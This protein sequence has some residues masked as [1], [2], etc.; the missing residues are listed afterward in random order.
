MTTESV[1]ESVRQR[2]WYPFGVYPNLLLLSAQIFGI[3]IYPFTDSGV[4]RMAFSLVQ[5]VVLFLAV[6]AV[7]PTPAL[8]WISMAC[9]APAAVLTVLTLIFPDSHGL[10][11]A[12]DLTH[13]VFFLYLGYAL[14]RYMFADRNVTADEMYA[15]ASTFTVLA[16]AFA[17]LYGVVQGIWGADQF[18]ATGE[19]DLE[20][21][22]MLFLSFTT[23]TGTG[24]SDISPVGAHA[25]SVVMLEQ[26]A[27]MFYIGLVVA[28]ML[29]LTLVKFQSRD[30]DKEAAAE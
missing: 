6:A 22:E 19:G 1:S 14:I 5:L 17:H 28:R 16:W 25:R 18:A 10:L 27:G 20:W 24:L 12:S 9:G 29:S 15:T 4:G 8:S 21:M 3:L 7:R 23:M 11:L 26:M 13:A 30:S 2:V